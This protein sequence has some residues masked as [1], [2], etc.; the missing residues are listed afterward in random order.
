M[1]VVDQV[2]SYRDQE[3]AL[4]GV[5]YTAQPSSGKDRGILL[6]HGG[7]GLDDHA[8]E[9]GWRY[10]E[11]GFVVFACDL[12]GDHVAGNRDR[13]IESLIDMRNDPAQLARRAGAGLEILARHVELSKHR[14]AI[15]YCFGGMAA[16]ELARSGAPL[17]SVVSIHGTLATKRPA[18]AGSVSAKILVCHGSA[19]PHVPLA[20]VT[21]FAAEMNAA[22]ADWQL[23]IYGRAMHG[24]THKTAA[25]G[26]AAG[27]EYNDL[28]DQRSYNA[29][30]AFLTQTLA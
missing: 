15:G 17:S 29:A 6:I 25:P 22:D 20:D 13:I 7:A 10:A 14:A 9:Q 26:G 24:F 23:V 28:A 3:V 18:T 4:T 5:L 27:I 1:R 2:I 16:L 19:D 8:R 12:L 11:A 30:S 21:A